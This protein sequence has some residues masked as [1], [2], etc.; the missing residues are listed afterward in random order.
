MSSSKVK[1]TKLQQ[2]E[3]TPT[4][5]RQWLQHIGAYLIL[6]I[7]A[8]IYFKPAAFDGKTLNQHDNVQAIAMQSEIIDYKEKQNGKEIRWTNQYFGGMPTALMRNLNKN[9]IDRQIAPAVTLYFGYNEWMLLF[10]IMLCGYIGLSLMGVNWV[11]S[12]GLSAVL[13]LFTANILY[14][15]AGHTG[16]MVVV[17]TVPAILGAFVYA[18]KRNL[19]LGTAI[20][21]TV[22]SFN[23]AKNHVQMT[24]YTYFGLTILG[25]A[26]FVEAIKR[27]T[28]P[29]FAKFAT[30]MMLASL[31]AVLSNIGFLW[32]S[33]EYG[34]E[35]TRGTTELT[36]KKT[37]SGQEQ[38]KSGL[39][40]DYIFSL[41]LEKA[42]IGALM[43]PN[44]YG[45]TQ[46]KLW[47]S[48]EGSETQAAFRSPRVQ[49][50]LAAAAKANGITDMNQFFQT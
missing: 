50:E 45:A 11:V 14:I 4:P 32:P 46:S 6:L 39:N 43:F 44:F 40:R 15:Q 30:A 35:S 25:I 22:L 13:A 31:L 17:S 48:N 36:E 27:G 18:Y 29:H 49:Q 24:Y 28:I 12:M 5:K 33:Y 19:L 3:P 8:M 21:A 23:L 9:H 7:I 1:P 38:T 20:F 2:L 34:Q 41:S 26:F 37:A 47:V 42:E 10:L 16:K